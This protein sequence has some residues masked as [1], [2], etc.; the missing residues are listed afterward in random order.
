ML[1]KI[2]HYNPNTYK[3]LMRLDADFSARGPLYKY[4]QESFGLSGKQLKMIVKNT[5][6]AASILHAACKRGEL[7]FDLNLQEY[8]PNGKVTGNTASCD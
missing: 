3:R 5:S 7:R 4:V 8:L 1:E 2:R 6:A